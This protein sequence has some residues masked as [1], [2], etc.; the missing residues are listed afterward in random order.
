MIY[1]QI[2][3]AKSVCTPLKIKNK[4]D[5][6]ITE[7]ILVQNLLK[8]TIANAV[9]ALESV[10]LHSF[11][12]RSSFWCS[13]F[14]SKY[15]KSKDHLSLQG[16]RILTSNFTGKHCFH[17]VFA[18]CFHKIVPPSEC[19]LWWTLALLFHLFLYTALLVLHSLES[20]EAV[21][22]IS[23]SPRQKL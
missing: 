23:W 1:H 9:K 3:L 17:K 14:W 5:W 18:I 21:Y 11:C 7:N 15:L 13:T 2:G 19:F 12:S 4:D 22:V 8:F 10:W 20:V 16:K 6:L